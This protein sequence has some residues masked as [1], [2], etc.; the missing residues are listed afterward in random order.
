MLHVK[1]FSF[2]HV[3]FALQVVL[4]VFVQKTEQVQIDFK[5][6]MIIAVLFVIQ[7]M[8]YFII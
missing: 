4:I 6:Q 3:S 5:I 1:S 8:I 7:N 2:F